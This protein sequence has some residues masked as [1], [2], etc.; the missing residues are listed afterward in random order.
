MGKYFKVN[1]SNLQKHYKHHLSGY[2]EWDQLTHAENWILDEKNIGHHICLDEVALSQGELYTVL[3]NASA[4]CQQGSLIAMVKGTKSEDIISL[5]ETVSLKIRK[6]VKQVTVDLAPNMEKAARICFPD[7]TIISDRF[8]VQQLPS[9]ALQ[10]MRV[11]YRWEAI[12]EENKAVKEAKKEAKK[13]IPKIFENGD[14]KKQLLARSRYLLFKPR[15][16]WTESQKNRARI[17]FENYPDLHKGYQLSMMF[18][19]I[20]ETASSP[21]NAKEQLENWFKKIEKYAYESFITAAHSIE[22]HQETILAFFINR[23]TNALAEAF[24]SKIKAFRATFRGV[25]DI[26]FFL[27]RVSLIFA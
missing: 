1:G 16:K 3:T 19:N 20:Y 24:N 15:S 25:R 6:Q 13:Y 9:D 14:T 17:L 7:A 10:E 21:E 23:Q 8:H 11:K 18:R 27:Y 2:T 22:I 12:E 5:L 4:A 26:K